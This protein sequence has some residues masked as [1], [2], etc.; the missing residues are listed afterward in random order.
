MPENKLAYVDSINRASP[1]ET[2]SIRMVP[3]EKVEK[4]MVL[5]LRMNEIRKDYAPGKD[6]RGDFG[7]RIDGI[8]QM[9]EELAPLLASKEALLKGETT[10]RLTGKVGTLQLHQFLAPEDLNKLKESGH[11][12]SG[13]IIKM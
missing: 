13:T 1:Y 8:R 10:V 11:L 4:I 3:G 12:H 2:Y 7:K 9:N 5:D 6:E